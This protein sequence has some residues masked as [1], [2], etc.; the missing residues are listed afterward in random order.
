M[1]TSNYVIG[2]EKTTFVRQLLIL[3]YTE[4]EYTFGK[5]FLLAY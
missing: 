3:C 4:L 1:E 5:M 2:S